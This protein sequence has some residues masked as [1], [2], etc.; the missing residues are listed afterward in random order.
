ML[1]TTVPFGFGI[2]T[3]EQS[4]KWWW[5]ESHHKGWFW[6]MKPDLK[7]KL[8]FLIGPSSEKRNSWKLIPASGIFGSPTLSF[9][10][11][12]HKRDPLCSMLCCASIIRSKIIISVD[13][14]FCNY[15]VWLCFLTI[16]C[17]DTNLLLISVLCD[18]TCLLVLDPVF[19]V[20]RAFVVPKS[21]ECDHYRCV[22]FYVFI[23][24]RP[25]LSFYST[26]DHSCRSMNY[27]HRA[28]LL[29][30][31][32]V[33]KTSGQIRFEVMCTFPG[34]ASRNFTN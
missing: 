17:T 12:D 19:P 3:S 7:A 33:T 8:K 18:F 24:A 30:V 13:R 9:Y 25:I 22:W 6:L 34:A 26:A 32:Y 16:V 14:Y 15:L 2:I 1:R 28:V 10:Y 11:T 20:T 29:L 5:P 23:N 27:C 31:P 21:M 4:S